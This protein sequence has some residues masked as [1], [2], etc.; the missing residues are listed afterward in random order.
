MRSFLSATP[1]ANFASAVSGAL[2]RGGGAAAEA[3]G[4]RAPVAPCP[5]AGDAL[6]FD[7]RV[8]HRGL[9]NDA[10]TRPVLVFTLAQPGFVDALNWPSRRIGDLAAARDGWAPD[11]SGEWARA[12]LFDGEGG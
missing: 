9:A 5:R 8:L 7:Y 10:A 2:A 1:A 11:L 3:L 12:A 6:V 4:A